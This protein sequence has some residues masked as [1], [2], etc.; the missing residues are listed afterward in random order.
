MTSFE[1]NEDF[2]EPKR[3]VFV[4][5]E[6]LYMLHAMTAA[7]NSKDPST[8]VGACYV[9]QDG[10]ILSIGCNQVPRNWDED[11][12]PWGTKKEYGMQN[13][14]YTYV[15][16]AEMGGSLNYGGSLKDFEGS[17]LYV[18]LFPCSNCAKVIATLGVKKVVYLNA[19]TDNEDYICSRTLL[20][21][22][23]IEC[24]SF[25]ELDNNS[26][27]FV[28]LDVNKDEKNFISMKKRY[29]I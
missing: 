24:I 15:V 21:Y 5:Q 25:R 18:T 6:E 11:F 29:A 12:F 3:E 9:G 7:S 4:S 2:L 1:L 22:C 13:N 20:N 8:Q 19:R 23:G 26:L 28:Q 27:E 16:H 10:R 14:K 17:T